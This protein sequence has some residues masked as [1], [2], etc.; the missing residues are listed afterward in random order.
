M[1]TSKTLFVLG[2]I[3]SLPVVSSAYADGP[4]NIGNN[5]T[6][7]SEYANTSRS[8]EPNSLSPGVWTRTEKDCKT[9]TG[10]VELSPDGHTV[11]V[12][13]GGD[14]GHLVAQGV[15]NVRAYPST[16][17]C[18]NTPL[19]FS[20]HDHDPTQKVIHFDGTDKAQAFVKLLT[21]QNSAQVRFIS[22]DCSDK[23]GKEQHC[24]SSKEHP[25]PERVDSTLPALDGVNLNSPDYSEND[26]EVVTSGENTFKPLSGYFS[27]VNALSDD[28]RAI[29]NV[30]ELS[31]SAAANVISNAKADTVNLVKN[32]E[33][34]HNTPDQNQ[35]I[36]AGATYY[37]GK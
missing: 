14:Q 25:I 16:V 3:A 8:T 10:A 6:L 31:R 12:H 34:M 33:E 21:S 37:G 7:L 15:D 28:K 20:R 36:Q 35:A 1:K 9:Q 27:K 4:K 29:V 22:W 32:V 30:Y 11:T 13:F 2:F 23:A 26:I 17:D 19:F 24:T 18:G 5:I